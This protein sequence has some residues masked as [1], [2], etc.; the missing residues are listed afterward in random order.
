MA[1]PIQAQ[2]S[3]KTGPVGRLRFSLSR[4]CGEFTKMYHALFEVCGGDLQAKS[5]AT[6]WTAII[7]RV[8][9]DEVRGNIIEDGGLHWIAFNDDYWL[10]R[11][12][13][14][15]PTF[16][17]ALDWLED[18]VAIQIR[19]VKG[20][21][22][23]PARQVA[24]N[25]AVVEALIHETRGKGGN[26]RDLE[27][28]LLVGKG[29]MLTA[30]EAKTVRLEKASAKVRKPPKPKTEKGVDSAEVSTE[31]SIKPFTD[32][33]ERLDTYPSKVI[34]G[35]YQAFSD[36]LAS[37]D[38][39]TSKPL[40]TKKKEE[41]VRRVKEDIRDTIYGNSD[42][43]E[44]SRNTATRRASTS[45]LLR[46]FEHNSFDS[47]DTK[48][49]HPEK[50]EAT[51]LPGIDPEERRIPAPQLTP[52]QA[53]ELAKQKMKELA[54]SPDTSEPWYSIGYDKGT[55]GD[56]AQAG[57]VYAVRPSVFKTLVNHNPKS[58]IGHHV[59]KDAN[60]NPDHKKIHAI[61]QT[62]HRIAGSHEGDPDVWAPVA[63]ELHKK[64][65]RYNSPE[66][67]SILAS[68]PEPDDPTW[69]RNYA[70]VLGLIETP[71]HPDYL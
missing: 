30:E 17:A 3:K 13:M 54:P 60:G 56:A 51:K 58:P 24:L 44:G 49:E 11:L 53:W 29:V 20:E 6:V 14:S 48:Q 47:G 25:N 69:K 22:G 45:A 66:I 36:Q 19:K 50:K 65:P 61:V 1:T 16:K 31:T 52:R 63:K 2:T 38:V 9:N 46:N 23:Y 27:Y 10:A 67:Q 40:I 33:H 5:T 26:H 57:Y 15:R 34:G 64:S 62:W 37:L 12:R 28:P 59:F 7:D 41:E 18:A 8:S 35:K 39:P 55:V 32:T 21:W 71:A 42:G 70:Y 68:F 43:E 4:E